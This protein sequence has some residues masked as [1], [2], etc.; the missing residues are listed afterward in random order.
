M[1]DN[2]GNVGDQRVNTFISLIIINDFNALK[3]GL[4]LPNENER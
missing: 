3:H 4:W 1:I 2:P